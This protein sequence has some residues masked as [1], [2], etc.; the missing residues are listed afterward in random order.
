MK[1]T[2]KEKIL[3]DLRRKMMALENQTPKLKIS[4][5]LEEIKPAAK[6]IYSFAHSRAGEKSEVDYIA[7]KKNLQKTVLLSILIFIFIVTLKLL[8]FKWSA[9]SSKRKSEVVRLDKHMMKSLEAL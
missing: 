8:F 3:A 1:K 9:T 7:I 6:P 5:D 4:E 2:K